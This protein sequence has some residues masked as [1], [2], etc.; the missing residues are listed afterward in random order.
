MVIQA[1]QVIYPSLQA[2]EQGMN[3]SGSQS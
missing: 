2:R 1:A 3:K